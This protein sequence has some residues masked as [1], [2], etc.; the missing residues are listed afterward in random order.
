VDKTSNSYVILFAVGV[1]VILATGLAAT[2]NGLKDRIESND[3][4]DKHRNVL[5]ACGLYDPAGSEKT[6]AELAAMFEERVESR[7]IEFFEDD[8]E[9]RIKVRGEEKTVTEKQVVR[10]QATDIA[11]ADLPKERRSQPGRIL[12]EFYVAKDDEGLTVYCIPISG[13]GLWSTLYGFLALEADRNTVRGITF[14][15]HGE[16][17]GLGG[18]VEKDW[19]QDDW[20]QKKTHDAAGNLVSVTVLKGR[21]NTDRNDH[22]VDGISGA[23][24]TSNGVTAFVRSDLQMYEIYFK[25]L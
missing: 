4:F 13:Y 8:V 24:I 21:N 12:G 14:Y 10:A 7:V 25:T 6:Q 5:I 1:C 2:F 16:T 23:T 17:P 20:V 18:E 22:Q 11:I 19:W 15:K 9:S 3:L